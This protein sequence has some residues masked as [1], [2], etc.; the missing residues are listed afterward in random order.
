MKWVRRKRVSCS[1][2]TS[3][4][5]SKKGV[6]SEGSE[7]SVVRGAAIAFDRF[8]SCDGSHPMPMDMPTITTT[9]DATVVGE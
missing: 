9:R 2:S 1:C 3:P 8:E 6:P 5:K 7:P 4:T